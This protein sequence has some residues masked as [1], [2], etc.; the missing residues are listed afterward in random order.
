MTNICRNRQNHEDMRTH[1]PASATIISWPILSYLLPSPFSTSILF[2]ANPR[3]NH[4][5]H[6]Y[7]HMQPWKIRTPFPCNCNAANIPQMCN[8]RLLNI[9]SV[10]KFPV[11]SWWISSFS[12]FVWRMIQILSTFC[13]G[14]VSL[15]S[16]L[17][18]IF[19]LISRFPFFLFLFSFLFQVHLIVEEARKP[20]HKVSHSLDRAGRTSSPP[21]SCICP[22]PQIWSCVH[23]PLVCSSCWWDECPQW[24]C[25]FLPRG[26]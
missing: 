17:I 24:Q 19:P 13:D 15:K 23:I 18:H 3:L 21:C 4:P 16:L 10:F 12:T 1:D 8:I 5:V 26:P 7:F 2:E 9:R 6:K 25:H 22:C 20:S 14:P 11:T